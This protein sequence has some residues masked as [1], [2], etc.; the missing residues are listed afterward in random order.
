[1]PLQPTRE[2]LAVDG[3]LQLEGGP[4]LAIGDVSP[5]PAHTT[6][7]GAGRAVVLECLSAGGRRPVVE[8]VE[9]RGERVVRGENVLVLSGR[10]ALA[11]RWRGL[12]VIDPDHVALDCHGQLRPGS[13]PPR[14]VLVGGS[15]R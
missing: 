3:V 13:A 8:L 14:L 15:R 1:M 12:T 6:L 4:S 11:R 9:L 2:L 7:A 5:L 10:V